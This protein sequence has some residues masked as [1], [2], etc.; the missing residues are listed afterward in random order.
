[1]TGA[2]VKNLNRRT[3]RSIAV[4]SAK[5]TLMKFVS[6]AG[7]LALA[8]LLLDEAF[9]II[10]IAFT[11]RAYA[12][13]IQ[14]MGVR[15]VLIAK[16]ETM[17]RWVNAGFWLVLFLGFG[18]AALMAIAAFPVAAFMNR[19]ELVGV[20]MVLALSQPA[21]A[22]TMVGQAMVEGNLRFKTTAVVEASSQTLQIAVMVAA[23]A[24]GFGAYSFA[25]G[26]VAMEWSRTI[27]LLKAAKPKI[28][29][30][31]DTHRWP[32]FIKTSGSMIGSS[33]L[34]RTL[35]QADY[36]ILAIITRSEAIVGQY[37][38][39]FNQSTLIAQL[40]VQSLVRVLLSGLSALYKEPVR[41]VNAFL[42]AIRLIV[43]ISVPASVTQATLARPFLT[44]L[45]G[46]KW[47]QAIPLLEI[48]SIMAIF[49]AA[50]WPSRSLLLAQQRYM[51][52]FILR[53]VGVAAFV[54]FVSAG[55]YLGLYLADNGSLD[56]AITRE[57]AA[58]LGVALGVALFR[59]LYSPASLY[60]ACRPGNIPLRTHLMLLAKPLAGAL[61]TI[62]PATIA[63]R[64]A[65]DA[66]QLEGAARHITHICVSPPLGLFA[67]WLWCKTVQKTE[68][69]EFRTQ[70]AHVLP[71]KINNKIPAWLF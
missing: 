60:I 32:V 34:E 6:A 18:A 14:D 50:G 17:N 9:G 4:M 46:D 57:A 35:Q 53:V 52:R 55:G 62:L 40:F 56:P 20:T 58:A 11:I 37:F 30:R 26:V 7:Q 31:F 2:P 38:F 3:T 48:L 59:T 67:Y 69:A 71:A 23:A 42:R 10:A 22:M 63:T 33:F 25:F 61:L 51:T 44:L 54:V 8:A 36:A 5:T 24:L 13:L 45:F 65:I 70:L 43:L 39:A 27:M 15:E 16:Q 29:R 12:N 49:A 66:A 21:Q 64:Y 68:L 1:M 28:R 47:Q 19:P 41:Q